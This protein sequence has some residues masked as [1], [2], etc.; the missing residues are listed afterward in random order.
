MRANSTGR[1]MGIGG[2]VACTVLAGTGLASAPAPHDW[3]NV[4]DH[5]ASGSTFTTLAR[6]TAGSNKI[7]VADVGDFK[8]GQGVMVSKCNVGYTDSRLWGPGLKISRAKPVGKAMAMRGYDGSSGSW[9]VFVVDVQRTTPPAFRWSDDLGRTWHGR[10]TR[11]TGDWQ[12]L[13]G[14]TQ[15][16]FGKHDWSA[17]WV[18]TFS[19]R[20]QLDTVIER[21]DGKVLTLRDAANRSVKDSVVRHNDTSALQAVLNRAVKEKRHVYVPNGTYRLSRGLEVKPADGITIEGQSAEHTVLDISEGVGAC[22][23]LQ[24]GREATVRNLRMVGHTGYD[25]RD[26]AGSMRTMGTIGLWGFYLKPCYAVHVRHTERVLVENC[27]ATRMSGEAFYC[28]SRSRSKPDRDVRGTKTL[29]YWRCSVV[30]S[31]RNAFNNNDLAENTAVLYCRIVDVGGC[32]W[33]GASRFVKFIGNYVRNGGT[34]AMGNIGTRAAYLEVL[35]SGQHIIADNTFESGVCY[36][37]CA[38]RAAHGATQVVIR[39]NLFVNYG[40]SAIEMTGRADARHLPSGMG[41][42]TGNILDMT[43]VGD[44][45]RARFAIHVN[46][47]HMIVSDNQVYVRDQ[48]DPKVTAIRLEEPAVNLNVHDNLIR[49]CGYGIVTGRARS[50][51]KEVIDPVT[52]VPARGGAASVPFER[53]Q[54]H[55]YRGWHLGWIGGRERNRVS[56]IETFDPETLRFKLTRPCGMKPGDTFEVFAPSANWHIHDN[57]ITGCV[58]PVVL[59]SYG[60]ATSR[61]A[62]NIITRGQ[63]TGVKEAVVVSGRFKLIGNHLVGF[64]EPGSVALVLHADPLGRVRPSVYT[65]NIFERCSRAVQESA[66]GLWQKS[67]TDGNTFIECGAAPKATRQRRGG[68]VAA[69]L[70]E[71][72]KRTRPVLRAPRRTQ[73]VTVDGNVSEWPW[74]DVKRVVVLERLPT[75][76]R[77]PSPRGQACAAWDDKDLYVAFRVTVA[78]GTKLTPGLAYRGDG[79]EVSLRGGGPVLILWGTV[80]GRF[81]TV[82]SES[83]TADQMQRLQ[84]ATSFAARTT[85][86]GWA[87]EWRIALGALG[88]K[89]TRPTELAFNIGVRVFAED[90]WVAWVPTGGPLCH[91][92]LAGLLRLDR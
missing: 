41:I 53:R 28:Q 15:V 71:A 5:G 27:H 22:I 33:E 50:R 38:I 3:L 44:A 83:A 32:T 11:I 81:N 67:V 46:A 76:E 66:K 56:T 43:G 26:Q 61:L 63:A 69:A 47:S 64:D 21:I 40:T 91:V 10:G 86:T 65:G 82:R 35:G 84:K 87:G 17:G 59:D 49:H 85:P 45:P 31:A 19:A 13:S 75:G 39:N 6:T 4:T 12:A 14:G 58:H 57:T 89:P 2:L 54:S 30:D 36:G 25:R 1:W 60:S 42:I 73:A 90:T 9:T 8:V 70:V 7:V 52:F 37:G 18:V 74:S 48:I 88:V 78:K 77:V 68:T 16:R 29:V 20:D 72:P 79:V 92:D 23:T 80:D 34:V 24:D 55:R 62:D 51:I